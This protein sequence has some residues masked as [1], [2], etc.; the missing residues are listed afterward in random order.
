MRSTLRFG[1]AHQTTS[2]APARRDQAADKRLIRRLSH[3]IAFLEKELAGL[4]GDTCQA[5]KAFP[6]G[7]KTEAQ[8]KSVPGVGDLTART[9]QSQRPE[10]GTIGRHQIAAL[11]GVVPIIRDPGLM[12]GRRSIAGEPLYGACCT[13]RADCDPS[14]LSGAACLTSGSL[15][16]ADRGRLLSWR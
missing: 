3:H 6:V 7:C 1:R 4:D 2:H 5:I 10:L 13:W 16:V 9:L 8:L 12:Q 11:V 15:R 14:R